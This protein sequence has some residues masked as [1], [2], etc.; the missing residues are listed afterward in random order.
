MKSIM[1]A[2]TLGGALWLAAPAHGAEVRVAANDSVQSVLAAQKGARVT[3]RLRSGQEMTGV[4]REVTVRMVHLG[5][6]T[7]REFFD[8]V[9]PLDAVD[10][11]LIRTKE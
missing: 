4:L 1:Y 3:L 7:G 9:I 6:L 8:A 10:A 2:I 5:A 11:V